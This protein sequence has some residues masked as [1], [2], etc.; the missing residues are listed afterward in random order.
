M[1]DTPNKISFQPGSIVATVGALRVAN[2]EQIAAIL[3]R[4]LAGDWGDLSDEDKKVNERAVKDGERLFSSYEI[5][6]DT[7][8]WIVTE[9]DRSS[10]CVLTPGEY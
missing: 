10:T 6:P 2:H 1:T 3:A 7:K 4:H 5:A 9:A 8:L